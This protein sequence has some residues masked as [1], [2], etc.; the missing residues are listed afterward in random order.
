MSWRGAVGLIPFSAP[1]SILNCRKGEEMS[2]IRVSLP[3]LHRLR[4]WA[5]TAALFRRLRS[6]VT[7]LSGRSRPYRRNSV[8]DARWMSSLY[9]KFYEQEDLKGI[10]ETPADSDTLVFHGDSEIGEG[11][12]MPDSRTISIS[13]SLWPTSTNVS[14]CHRQEHPG[15]VSLFLPGVLCGSMKLCENTHWTIKTGTTT[16]KKL[17]PDLTL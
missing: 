5:T 10:R 12:G 17:L 13:L 6:M 15:P 11:A 3:V 9:S 16:L 4:C 1:D 7:P 14:N 2:S 8:I